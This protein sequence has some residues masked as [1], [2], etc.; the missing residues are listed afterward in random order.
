[1]NHSILTSSFS[2]PLTFRPQLSKNYLLHWSGDYFSHLFS[3]HSGRIRHQDTTYQVIF[4]PS[5]SERE[6]LSSTKVQISFRSLDGITGFALV[7][8]AGA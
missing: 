6:V 3:T 2:I 8:P 4:D 1:M 7:K 5:T